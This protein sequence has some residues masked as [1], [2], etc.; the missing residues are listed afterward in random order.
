[1][2][3]LM[4]GKNIMIVYYEKLK[5]NQLNSTL[6][7]IT[8]F[9]NHTIANKRLDCFNKHS[10]DFQRP[11][12]CIITYEKEQRNFENKYIYS[13]KHAIWINSAIRAVSRE[14]KKRGFDTLHLLSYQNTNLK[15]IYCS[16]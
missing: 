6:T 10:R 5:T 12:K 8:S 3:W 16:S 13:K 1:M 2:D 4:K 11:E 14:A 7:S 15:L 9:L